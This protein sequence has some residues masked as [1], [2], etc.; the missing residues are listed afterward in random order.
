MTLIAMFLKN[1]VISLM[2][3][4]FVVF[5][6][7]PI[8]AAIERF[9]VLNDSFYKVSVKILHYILPKVSETVMLINNLVMSKE[10]SLGSLWSSFF[11]GI[12]AV[13]LSLVFFKKSDF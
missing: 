3:T 2:L 1:G 7:S 4:Y 13:G 6:L 8:I 12:I 9:A 11:T 5:I 10:F